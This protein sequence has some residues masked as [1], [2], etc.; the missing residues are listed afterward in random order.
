LD[1]QYS[2]INK[3]RKKINPIISNSEETME[4]FFKES[5]IMKKVVNLLNIFES[6]QELQ[7]MINTKSNKLF[8]DRD[9]EVLMSLSKYKKLIRE[10]MQKMGILLHIY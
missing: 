6:I 5:L 10:E 2:S 9:T 8:I 4:S 3:K 1:T 7:N